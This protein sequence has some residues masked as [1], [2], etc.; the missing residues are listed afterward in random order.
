MAAAQNAALSFR[1]RS[2]RLYNIDCYF[3]DA[4]GGLATFN[5]SGAAVAGSLTY[6]RC[7]EAVVLEDFAMHTGTTQTSAY[8][9]EDG[10]VKNGAV[11]RFLTFLDTLNNRPKLNIPFAAGSLFGITTI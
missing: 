8:C 11:L 6:W 4:A 7:P 1:G 10:A 3:A 5:P 9:T 2:G